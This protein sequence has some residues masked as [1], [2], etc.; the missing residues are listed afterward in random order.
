MYSES[1]YYTLAD[2]KLLI[3]R[4]FA[5]EIIIK[6]G[7]KECVF[8]CEQAL[9]NSSAKPSIAKINIPL[10]TVCSL[11]CRYCVEYKNNKT[12]K[13]INV[14]FAQLAIRQFTAY[15]RKNKNISGVQISFDYGGE[16]LSQPYLFE[17][18]CGSFINECC[19]ASLNWHIQVTTNACFPKEA[20]AL[21]AQYKTE[22]IVSLD[23]FE[24]L[25]NYGRLLKT[26]GGSFTQAFENA[27]RL[28]ELGL[29][30]HFSCVVHEETLKYPEKLISFFADNFPG[31]KLR[32]NPIKTCELSLTN[33]FRKISLSEWS[34]FIQACQAAVIGKNI[35]ILFIHQNRDIRY[36]YFYGCDSLQK[37]DWFCNF[38]ESISSCCGKEHISNQFIFGRLVKKILAIDY[39]LLDKFRDYHVANIGLCTSCIAKYY[40]AGHC[41]YFRE[42]GIINC[43]NRKNKFAEL[44]LHTFCAN[45]AIDFG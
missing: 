40:C 8:S 26:G 16:P 24:D 36:L 2:S 22:V 3:F 20:L 30:K 13:L 35:S 28:F 15:F 5:Q 6:S 4:P 41:P 42:N 38:D 1:L 11:S 21:L 9:R 44:L 23:G 33:G 10:S 19:E 39:A 7:N 32:L 29:I 17:T 25:H 12:I 45:R 34:N 14:A 37:P 18:I 43:D 27:K 31:S